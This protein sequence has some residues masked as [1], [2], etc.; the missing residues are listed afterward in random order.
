MKSNH[1]YMEYDRWTKEI[2]VTIPETGPAGGSGGSQSVL[3]PRKVGPDQSIVGSPKYTFLDPKHASEFQEIIY[4]KKLKATYSLQDLS[5][6]WAGSKKDSKHLQLKV[7]TDMITRGP[8]ADFLSLF[9]HDDMGNHHLEF[10]INWFESEVEGDECG[11]V[12]IRFLT[13][14]VKPNTKQSRFLS[15]INNASLE[16]TC[17][18]GKSTSINSSTYQ[19]PLQAHAQMTQ[20]VTICRIN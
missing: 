8:P 16:T 7:W 20:I 9:V 11:I 12:T 10:P 14:S 3:I 18:E 5:S 13:S 19:Q 1:P 4:G 6:A 15:G 2:F 17:L